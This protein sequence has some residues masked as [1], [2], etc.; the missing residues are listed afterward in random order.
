[1]CVYECMCMYVCVCLYHTQYV[2]YM[3]LA[4]TAD[5]VLSTQ[6]C[7]HSH[8]VSNGF[9]VLVGESEDSTRA[10]ITIICELGEHNLSRWAGRRGGRGVEG[11]RWEGERRGEGTVRRK[12]R[13]AVTLA[14]PV[15]KQLEGR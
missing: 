11:R 15:P 6:S 1:M 5:N 13:Q 10:T 12:Y 4:L 7:Y 14:S 9:R 2:G 8:L 3:C